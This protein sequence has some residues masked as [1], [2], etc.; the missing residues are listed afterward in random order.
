MRIN[1]ISS[2][3][4]TNKFKN[5]TFNGLIK[6]K[7]ALPI[8]ESMS[9]TDKTELRKI[10]K[11]LSK[12]RFWDMKISS[13]GNEFKEFKVKFINKNSGGVITDGIYPYDHKGKTINFYSIVYGPENT[14]L[15]N[16]E[17]LHFKSEKRA[18]ELYDKYQQNALYTRNRG[19]NISPIESLKMK[20]VELNMLEEA[21]KTTNGKRKITQVNTEYKTKQT[22][23]N[24]LLFKD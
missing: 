10:E 24:D 3:Y 21:S 17:T 1:A 2:N 23:G 4:E 6:E 18:E 15:N 19:Y 22:T 14:S 16:I 5:I 11:R 7:S 13:I 12:A 8:I 9:D 20:E